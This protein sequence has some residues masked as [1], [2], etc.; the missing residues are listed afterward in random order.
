[1]TKK[2]KK[3]FDLK[4]WV[5][6]SENFDNLEILKAISEGINGT[7]SNFQYLQSLEIEIQKTLKGKKFFLVLDDV[8]NENYGVWDNFI[9][10][11][12][13]EAQ[14]VKIIVTTRSE[15]VARVVTVSTHY[16][17]Y[18]L[19]NEDCMKIFVHSAFGNRNPNEFPHLLEIGKE[20]VEKCRGLPLAAKTLGGSLR[21][22]FNQNDWIKIWKSHIWDLLD[23]KTNIF[24]AL[25]LSYHYIP[26]HLKRCF[27]YCSI[28]PKDYE[29]EKEELIL[30]WMAEGLLQ[31]PK[32]ARCIELEEIGEEYFNDLVSRSFFQQSSKSKSCFLMHDL[33]NDLAKSICGKFCFRLEESNESNE[34]TKETRHLSYYK[35]GFYVSKEFEIPSEAKG[36]R[37]LL[38]KSH[39]PTWIFEYKNIVKIDLNFF[40]NFKCLRVL[41]LY[42]ACIKELPITVDNLIHLRYLNTCNTGIKDLPDSLCN[43]YNLQTLILSSYIT[44]LPA[45]TSKLI[46]LRHLD[47]SEANME[48]MPPHMGKMKN[49]IKLYVFC[50]GKHDDGS[51]IKELGELQHLSGKLSLLNL[52]NVRCIDK[53]TKEVILKN[54]QDLSELKLEWEHGHG[55]KDSEKEIILLEKLCP[56]TNLNSLTITNYE[57]TSF[58]K[59][60]GDSSFSKMVFIKLRNCLSL[61]PLGQLPSLKSL[62]IECFGEISS[63]GLEFYGNTINPFRAL[64]YLSFE[65]MPEWQD[66]VLFKGEVF[67]CLRELYIK[68]CPK[69]SGGLPV[70]LP[71]LTKLNIRKCE[72]LVASLPNSPALHELVCS[73]KM[74]IPSGHDYQSLKSVFI[75]GGGDSILSFPP[76]F[77]S[78]TCLDF[79]GCPDLVSFPS[80]GLCAPILSQIVIHDCRNLKSLP[81]GMH[82]LLPSL[83]RLELRWCPE[84]ESFP[85][86][87]LPSSLESLAIYGCEKLISRRMELGL[88]GLH[89]L[90]SFTISDHRKE[91]E[92]F[93]EEAL[94][95]PNLTDFAIGILPY[96]KS[97][98]GKGFQTLTSLKH[99]TIWDCNNLDG[100]LE[101]VLPTSLY[102]LE[103]YNCRLLKERYGNEKGEGRVKIAHI[104]RISI[105]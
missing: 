94:L 105:R 82:T 64:E 81:E 1:M 37:T 78:L 83:V 9:K 102:Q 66:W 2:L 70:Q 29:F 56:C 10:V 35:A 91:L 36:L 93:P 15:K 42:G 21:S 85:E 75:E 80:R 11:F 98:N 57:G 62:K 26:S 54:K 53:D 61:P 58:P 19:S 90:R 25:K 104:P 23:A 72:Q 34:I 12:K 33:I 18:E 31:Q 41:S 92:P 101:D 44:K 73:G 22:N 16:F 96:L 60:L 79:C 74:Q 87:G 99:L 14:E 50:V 76:E 43:L 63:V 32:E 24:P 67:T 45:N 55:T 28:F 6:V 27:A 48:E 49:L 40:Q 97:L 100:L 3:S 13:C 59:W 89:S 77:A 46:N 84:L 51:N 103:I 7:A 69:L 39:L 38:V 17:L 47:N 88:Q 65:N 30:L 8:W 52:E 4:A 20:I 71:S 68:D 5:C 86:G 95:P